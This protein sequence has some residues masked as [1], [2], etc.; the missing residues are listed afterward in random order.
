[1]RRRIDSASARTESDL[2]LRQSPQD[3]DV[4][5]AA[6]HV[7]IQAGRDEDARTH[8]QTLGGPESTDPL[9]HELYGELE[10]LLLDVE[11]ARKAWA[12]ARELDPLRSST[13]VHE[14][15]LLIKVE[16]SEQALVLLDEQQAKLAGLPDQSPEVRAARAE[17]ERT[18]ATLLRSR[19]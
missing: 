15:A 11:A 7:A 1:M 14:V 19:A 4:L 3:R 8:L 17:L 18:R 16:Q 5:F 9:V 10:A 12:K 2:L 6:V 13:V